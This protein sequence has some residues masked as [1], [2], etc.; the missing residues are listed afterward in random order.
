MIADIR[1]DRYDHRSAEEQQRLA[2]KA[3]RGDQEAYVQ[4]CESNIRYA[5]KRVHRYKWANV[6]EK[7]LEGAALLGL[8]L[9]L[10]EYD[11][12]RHERPIAYVKNRIQDQIRKCIRKHGRTVRLPHHQ[13]V[14]LRKID[15]ARENLRQE[16][17]RAPKASEIAGEIDGLNTE[18]VVDALRR[19]YPSDSMDELFQED[20]DASDRTYLDIFRDSGVPMPDAEYEEEELHHIIDRLLGYLPDRQGKIIR[21]MLGANVDRGS[22]KQK[23]HLVLPNDIAEHFDVG[24]PRI[25]QLKRKALRTL[26]EWAQQLNLSAA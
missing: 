9:G 26:Q 10:R 21:L 4:L 6:P 20:D 8:C 24:L 13:R 22:G 16:L 12:D 3:R 2:R 5:M 11:P 23:G 1:E 19:R 18:Q 14:R 17:Y 7:D 15:R 25:Q